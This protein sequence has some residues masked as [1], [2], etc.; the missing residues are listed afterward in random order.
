MSCF[1]NE[2]AMESCY[3]EACE[4]AYEF[5]PEADWE[6]EA[7]NCWIDWKSNELF[8]ELPDGPF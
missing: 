4:L 5:F 1:A 7:F 6:G 3:E 2:S 8:S